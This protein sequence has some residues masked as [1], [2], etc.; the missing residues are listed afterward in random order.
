VASFGQGGTAAAAISAGG[1]SSLPPP[2]ATVQL[3][4][5]SHN[6]GQT[7]GAEFFGGVLRDLRI[8]VG[9]TNLSG[10]HTQ[11]LDLFS[12]DG[13]LY[14]RFSSALSGSSTVE[15]RLAVGGT[16][17]TEHSLFGAWRVDVFLDREE[18]PITSGVFVLGP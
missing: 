3:I 2:S 17:I 8:L 5:V 4:G 14:Q 10:T 16:W 7:G 15:T 6:G 11:H 9:W 13:S 18:M 12:P 1:S